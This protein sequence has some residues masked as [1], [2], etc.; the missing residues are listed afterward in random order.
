MVRDKGKK[1][2]EKGKERSWSKGPKKEAGEKEKKR[3][4]VVRD[5]RKKQE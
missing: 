2:E 5:Q 1:Q 3:E 4:A